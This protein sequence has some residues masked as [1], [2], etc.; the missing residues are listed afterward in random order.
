RTTTTSLRWRVRCVRLADRP[1]SWSADRIVDLT[2]TTERHVTIDNSQSIRA[3][4]VLALVFGIAACG[5]SDQQAQARVDDSEVVVLRPTDVATAQLESVAQSVVRT[6][7][8]NPYRTA[9]VRAQ[10]PGLVSALRV[11]RGDPVTAGQV[12][13]VLDAQGIRSSAAGA[14]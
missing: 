3:A 4:G 11:D 1:P 7:S 5:G 8:L 10:V 6:G 14:R 9:E 2:T 12:M 13:A